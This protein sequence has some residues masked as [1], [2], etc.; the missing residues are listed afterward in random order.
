M[1][2]KKVIKHFSMIAF[3][4]CSMI[5]FV[6]FYMQDQMNDY[7]KRRTTLSTRFAMLDEMEFPTMT[8]CMQEGMKESVKDKYGLSENIG[9]WFNSYGPANN[10]LSETFEDLSFILNRDSG[11]ILN[12]E[13]LFSRYTDIRGREEDLVMRQR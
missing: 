9:F 4:T 2:S 12:S 5:L 13:L 8:I 1:F 7:I 10:T 6:L 11:V 3:Y